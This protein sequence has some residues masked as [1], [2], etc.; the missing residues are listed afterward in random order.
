MN[1][2]L[3]EKSKTIVAF[4][5]FLSGIILTS[6]YSY[7]T[8]KG[9]IEEEIDSKLA[10]IAQAVPLVLP[11]RFHDAKIQKNTISPDADFLNIKKLSNFATATGVKYAY[12]VFED[13]QKIRFSASSATE[14]ELKTGK[15]LTRFFD[16]Y[17]D[18]DPKLHE[19]LKTGQHKY[20]S[21]E[22]KWGHFRSVFVPLKSQNGNI[23]AVGVDIEVGYIN[24]LLKKAALKGALSAA[25]VL[26]FA[27]P[28]AFLYLGTLKHHNM[29]LEQKVK[30]ATDKLRTLNASLEERIKEEVEKNSKRE[31]AMFEQSKLA[32]M[33]QMMQAVAHHWRQPLNALGMYVQ[34]IHFLY[35]MKELT[36]EDM[37]GFKNESMDVIQKMSKT[38]DSFRN[39]FLPD[40]QRL[41]FCVEDA[42]NEVITIVTPKMTGDNIELVDNKAGRHIVSGYKNEFKQVFLNL[43]TNAADETLKQNGENKKIEIFSLKKD[44]N[45]EI[46]VKDFG[47]GIPSE[48]VN[49]IFEPY[50]TTKEQGSGIGM[51]LY[52]SKE[53]IERHF[54]GTLRAENAEDGTLFVI[55]LPVRFLG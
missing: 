3:I 6:W 27:V 13:D 16:A 5:V 40:A 25:T 48:L 9:R 43:L 2:N 24:D 55:S 21:Y 45:I 23:Y 14:E 36:K 26:L 4:L 37:D 12:T 8:E 30:A 46:C 33:G 31:K 41:D 49:R 7:A 1:Y 28:L 47:G 32:Q 17:D 52:M 38:I 29:L 35:D 39:L 19:A 10:S 22:D 44:D 42:M 20:A 51:G 34:N 50:F 54:G 53:L 15:N 18:A 11:D